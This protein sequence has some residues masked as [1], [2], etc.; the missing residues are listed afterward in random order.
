[1]TE[2]ILAAPSVASEPDLVRAAP[3]AGVAVLRRCVD[4]VDL[5]AAAASASGVA[6]V[7]SA[8]VG[9]LTADVVADLGRRDR[10]LIGLVA[11][12]GDVELLRSVGVDRLVA[13]EPEAAA[14]WRAVVDELAGVAT[15][16]DAPT[17]VWST[18]CWVGPEAPPP[19]VSDPVGHRPGPRRRAGVVVAVWGPQGAPGR[20]T[21]ALG[22]ADALADD[23]R[24]VCVVDADTYAPSIAL[25]LGLDDTVSD[26]VVACRCAGSPSVGPAA[27]ANVARPVHGTLSA[28]GGITGPSR[29]E[30]L[31]PGALDR[32]WAACREAF[33]VTVVDV[34]FCLEQDDEP[35]LLR[36]S[37]NAAAVTAI[38][39]S[40]LVV[41]VAA[42]SHLGAA[43]L[44]S[45]WPGA[46]AVVAGRPTVVVRNR[47]GSR[48]RDW[49]R[50]VA[51][52]GVDAPVVDVPDDPA[53]ARQ[54]WA[55]G[56]TV[57]RAG[58]RSRLRRGVAEL[59]VTCQELWSRTG[60]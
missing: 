35:D 14:T 42:G 47:S 29:W 55:F 28:I 3:A 41:A 30:E 54:A 9:R 45:A 15:A 51:A 53:A 21:V 2:V 11:G 31:R 17:G 46:A 49:I 13:V 59:A 56:S 20:T 8:G 40:D 50:A 36:R 16:P 38:D 23:G 7:V 37:R 60:T 32:L 10:A 12:P 25:A 57:A 39:A 43:R 58:R 18:G 52:C 4:A 34:G 22:L 27:L 48:D 6:V 1:M 26:L 44:G 19:E 24:R 33:D 5:L